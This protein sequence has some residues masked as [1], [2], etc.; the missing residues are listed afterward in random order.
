MNLESAIKYLTESNATCNADHLHALGI[1]M[2]SPRSLPII[3]PYIFLSS[4]DCEGSHASF[5]A[6]CLYLLTERDGIST[7]VDL[8]NWCE[9]RDCWTRFLD[10]QSN[11]KTNKMA[12]L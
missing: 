10:D 8:D 4:L 5:A 6:R 7:Q 11:N 1:I 12:I 2:E 3:D 9:N